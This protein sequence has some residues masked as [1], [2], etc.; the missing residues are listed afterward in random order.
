MEENDFSHIKQE[1]HGDDVEL[2][3]HINKKKL[4]IIEE[5][6]PKDG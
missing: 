4:R 1:A 3:S 2:L 5:E 6:F